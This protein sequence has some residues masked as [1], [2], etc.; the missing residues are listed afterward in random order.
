M[1]DTFYDEIRRRTRRREV[2]TFVRGGPMVTDDSK[3]KDYIGI[4]YTQM[5]FLMNT[6]TNYAAQFRCRSCSGKLTN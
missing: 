2:C 4:Y 1:I 6:K 5:Q 3:P